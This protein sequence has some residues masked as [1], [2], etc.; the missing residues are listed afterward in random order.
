MPLDAIAADI[1]RTLETRAF[2]GSLKF[3]CGDVGVIVLADGTATTADRKTDCTLKISEDNLV[4]LLTGKLNPMAGVMTGKLKVS[5]DL[6][7]AMGLAKLL[8]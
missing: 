2:T 4:K 3:D 8:G 5:G 6:T 7:V 1:A